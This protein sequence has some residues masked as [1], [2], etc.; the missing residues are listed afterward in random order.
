MTYCP[1]VTHATC[2]M[3]S[4]SYTG[5]LGTGQCFTSRC[6]NSGSAVYFGRIGSHFDN[7]LHNGKCHKTGMWPH[8]AN[9]QH[10]CSTM[11]TVSNDIVGDE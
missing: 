6:I 3:C 2:N 4:G 5:E 8:F 11:I 9:L 10:V 1:N 7:V